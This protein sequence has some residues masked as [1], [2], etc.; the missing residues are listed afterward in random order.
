MEINELGRGILDTIP[1]KITETI[2]GELSL[3]SWSLF[4]E[5]TQKT[6]F[7]NGFTGLAAKVSDKINRE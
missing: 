7:G 2:D 5:L 4:G 3:S 6:G 1:A